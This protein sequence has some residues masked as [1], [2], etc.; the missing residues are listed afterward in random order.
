LSFRSFW[1]LRS[2]TTLVAL[3]PDDDIN[4][5]FDLTFTSSL[6]HIGSAMSDSSQDT[7]GGRVFVRTPR[8]GCF[9]VVEGIDGTGKSTL[10]R[11]LAT[12]LEKMGRVVL[13]S[14]EP[15]RGPHGMRLRDLMKEGRFKITPLEELD[16]FVADRKQHLEEKVKPALER[17]ETVILDRYF[18]STMAYQGVRG[19]DPFDIHRMHQEFAPEPDLLVILELPLDEALERITRERGEEPNEFEKREHLEQCSRIFDSIR[20]PNL[21]RMD[22]RLPVEELV[23]QVVQRIS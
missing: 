17:G 18:Y 3:N 1:P 20:H 19:L 9:I 13:T 10:V 16:L 6:I 2:L 8:K 5:D 7:A 21:M 23:R 4:I 22:S 12:E 11:M 14:A 15:T